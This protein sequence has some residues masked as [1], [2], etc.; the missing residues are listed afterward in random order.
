MSNTIS[1][2]AEL[3]HCCYMLGLIS[4]LIQEP[5]D[6]VSLRAKTHDVIY[7]DY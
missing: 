6:A 7:H 3:L 1:P 4:I 2:S 5:S